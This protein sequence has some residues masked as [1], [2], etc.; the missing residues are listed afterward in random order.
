MNPHVSTP[1]GLVSDGARLPGLPVWSMSDSLKDTGPV[2]LS[3]SLAGFSALSE[4]IS[5]LHTLP[6]TTVA[7]KR[8]HSQTT[9]FDSFLQSQGSP[10]R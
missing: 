6:E 7:L 10:K 1:A 5:N 4:C 2:P 8:Y 9:T 3:D